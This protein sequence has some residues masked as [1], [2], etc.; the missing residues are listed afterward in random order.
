MDGGAIEWCMNGGVIEWYMDCPCPWQCMLGRSDARVDAA[1]YSSDR[2]ACKEP[3]M[4][5]R[6]VPV[7]SRQQVGSTGWVGSV[8]KWQCRDGASLKTMMHLLHFHVARGPGPATTA[9]VVTAPVPPLA[10]TV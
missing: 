10:C 9:S 5:R 1:A 8:L 2:R 7:L 4:G 6:A 3:C